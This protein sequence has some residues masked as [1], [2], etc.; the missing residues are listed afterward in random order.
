MDR[1][2]AVIQHI[3]VKG[4][5]LA[6][7]ESCTGGLLSKVLTD[8]AGSSA[9]F[10]GGAV[11]YSNDSKMDILGVQED[12]FVKDGAVSREVAGVMAEGA[13]CL[14][15]ADIGIGI[16]GIAGPE[17]GSEEKPVGLVFIGVAYEDRVFTEELRLEGSRDD[18]RRGATEGALELLE[19]VLLGKV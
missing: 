10:L 15:G 1:S 14:F 16:T 6:V 4:L 13:A 19:A 11:T 2:E 9:F 12:L 3:M 18:V 17:G 7:A 8:R 5:T